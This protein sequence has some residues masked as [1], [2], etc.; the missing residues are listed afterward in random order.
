MDQQILALYAKGMSTRD[1][2]DAFQEMYGADVSA[3][4]I[5]KVT[6][7]VIEEVTEW[8]NRPL[9]AVYPIIY[10]DCLVIKVHQDKR[11]INKSVF[12]ALGITLAGNKELLGLWIAETEGSKF[13]LSVLTELQQRGVKDIFIACVDGL[14]GFPEAI[15][16]VY[17]QAKVQLCVVHLVRN[18]LRYVAS[19]DMKA[20]AADL[21]TIYQSV[22]ESQAQEALNAFD[23]KW[24]LKYPA[25]SKSWRNHWPHIIPLLAFPSEIRKIIYTT[26]AIESLNSV[27]RKSIS[28]RKIFPSDK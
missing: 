3:T 10:L 20:V 22:T 2:V 12:I 15:N 24:G 18:A 14:T 26:N 13:W 5:S 6:D 1:I 28:N 21:K 4:L 8:Q 11:V 9:E 25:I 7:A 17:P 27:I 19:K 23:E 16:I